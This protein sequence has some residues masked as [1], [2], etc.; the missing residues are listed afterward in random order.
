MFN[1]NTDKFEI[2]KQSPQKNRVKSKN[3]VLEVYGSQH[4]QNVGSIGQPQG[5]VGK[6]FL[7]HGEYGGYIW[8]VEE[9][10]IILQRMREVDGGGIQLAMEQVLGKY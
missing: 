1:T 4:S 2:N 3:S 7:F 6:Q 5:Y 8:I 9:F 10:Q